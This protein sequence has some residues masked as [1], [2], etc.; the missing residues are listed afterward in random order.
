LVLEPGSNLQLGTTWSQTSNN[1]QPG[2]LLFPQQTTNDTITSLAFYPGRSATLW[3]GIKTPLQ[4]LAIDLKQRVDDR[5]DCW[6]GPHS[7]AGRDYSVIVHAVGGVAPL[8]TAVV[9][10]Y[11]TD[12]LDRGSGARP[13][14]RCTYLEGF[15]F[16]TRV[17]FMSGD[18]GPGPDDYAAAYQLDGFALGTTPI[19]TEPK[20]LAPAPPPAILAPATEAGPNT[21][22]FD[23]PYALAVA[24]QNA[25]QD[26]SFTD[27]QDYLK[28]HPDAYLGQASFS[29]FT[30]QGSTHYEW[31][32]VATDGQA[33]YAFRNIHTPGP[34][35]ILPASSPVPAPLLLTAGGDSYDRLTNGWEDGPY[36]LP[37]D[38]PTMMPTV[39]S[40]VADWSVI[41]QRDDANAYGF[42]L[43]CGVRDDGTCQQ[44]AMF[45]AGF[46]SDDSS[47]GIPTAPG[48]RRIQG[49]DVQADGNGRLVAFSQRMTT[50]QY[51]S[52]VDPNPSGGG[53][54]TPKPA[55]LTTLPSG[56]RWIPTRD[57]AVAV[58][59]FALL[60]TLAYWLWPTLKGLAP[61]GLFSRVH[62]DRLMDNPLRQRLV[63]RIEAE[64]G[65]HH[66]ALVRELGNGK[67][68][69]EHHLHKLTEAKLV[70]R[71]RGVGYT[72]YFPIGT[73]RRSMA[74][75]PAL[76]SDGARRV[77]EAVTRGLSGVREVAAAT[78]LAP[79]TVSHHLERLRGAGLVVGGSGAGYT[80]AAPGSS[81]PAAGQ[82]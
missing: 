31:Y 7:W 18:A 6:N 81:V 35:E 66:N 14:M 62:K 44:R 4:G 78:G 2:S 33:Q 29:K 57:E 75:T 72:C 74:A 49:S 61:I 53:D 23:H 68:A 82:D 17:E 79:S 5:T 42:D 9:D 48:D 16:A 21:T 59:G 12:D 63:Q 54:P 24:W 51:G 47:P 69:I 10:S 25:K 56:M 67:G 1:T 80:A 38:R 32:I 26:A 8:R 40:L 20:V 34:A 22:G 71:H 37:A 39:A 11:Q 3:C 13:F 15:P 50:Q 52:L 76:K 77:L 65:I 45:F 43:R 41:A 64:P 19:A 28:A 60:A 73:D 36:P 46:S 30:E 27:L 55:E 70:L 58:G